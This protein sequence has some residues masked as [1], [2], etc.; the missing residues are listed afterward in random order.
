LPKPSVWALLHR[1]GRLTTSVGQTMSGEYF[2]SFQIDQTTVVIASVFGFLEFYVLIYIYSFRFNQQFLHMFDANILSPQRS[3]TF[4]NI[5]IFISLGKK[6]FNKI[7]VLKIA[8]ADKSFFSGLRCW[9]Y[10]KTTFPRT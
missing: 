3:L 1:L 7:F 2:K 10:M 5:S 9:C 8:F 4:R 6:W